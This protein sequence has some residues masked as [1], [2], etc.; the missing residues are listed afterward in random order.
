MLKIL[1]QK[2]HEY[3]KNLFLCTGLYNKN[4][5]NLKNL[6]VDNSTSIEIDNLNNIV[7]KFSVR[8]KN[9]NFFLD[10]CEVD[11]KNYHNG[12][13]FTFYSKDIRGEVARGG[14]YFTKNLK[15]TEIATGFTC[16]MDSI[17]RASSL[18]LVTNK[19]LIPFDTNKNKVNNLIEKGYVVLKYTGNSVISKKIAKQQNCQFYLLNNSIKTS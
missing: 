13:R 4:K 15:Q 19:I 6:S 10:L 16:Y 5:K 9:T 18:D 14:R 7:K 11:D 2:D 1:D 8:N 12:V 3:I 17:L